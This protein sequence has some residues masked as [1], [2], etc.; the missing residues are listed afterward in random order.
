MDRLQQKNSLFIQLGALFGPLLRL[1]ENPDQ[2]NDQE[3]SEIFAR[4][5]AE[6][7][8]LINEFLKFTQGQPGHFYR[9]EYEKFHA[10]L[11]GLSKKL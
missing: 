1:V 4:Y 9:L 3:R 2:Y 10:A 8:E 6:H 5:F 7:S 11:Y